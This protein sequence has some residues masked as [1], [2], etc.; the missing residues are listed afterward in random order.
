MQHVEQTEID[1]PIGRR[2]YE[3]M[4]EKGGAYSQQSVAAR[5][6]L[7]RETFRQMIS[8]K[9]EIY[10]FE[11][12]KISEVLKVPVDRLVMDDVKQ[13]Y[14][15]L[16]ALLR[17]L[18]DTRRALTLAE[19][20]VARAMGATERCCALEML[21]RAQYLLQR[22]NDAHCTWL[23]ALTYAKEISDR[24]KDSSHQLN[25]TTNLMLT[26]TIRK[27]YSNLSQLVNEVEAH[28][29]SKPSKSAVIC[30][31]LAKIAEAEKDFENARYNY[32]RSLSYYQMTDYQMWVGGAKLFTANFEYRMG[33]Y[34]QAIQMYQEAIP[35][36]YEDIL[37]TIICLKEYAKCL[38][39][40][41]DSSDA[42][43]LVHQ[44]LQIIDESVED[45]SEL[46][47]QF[48]L[49]LARIKN[50]PSFADAVLDNANHDVKIRHI[51]CRYLIH[52]YEKVDD[53][54]SLIKY[55]RKEQ[56]LNQK[57]YDLLDEED[58]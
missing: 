52:Y 50:D 28:L 53:A 18:K 36:L 34:T 43:Q 47:A 35:D 13:D 7:C 40:V 17:N 57:D 5:I 37:G 31:S 54:E 24:Y 30:Y 1:V 58:L 46:Q 27:E 56:A 41:G 45:Y 21:G 6:G 23:Q 4:K 51:A 16:I 14:K 2:I 38:L 11:M 29:D 49:L 9:R 33:N 48:N 19:K 32:Y 22:Y 42:E 10:D 15:E 3:I 20:L 55:H 44:A 25:I 39:K 8:G 26:Y 12:K